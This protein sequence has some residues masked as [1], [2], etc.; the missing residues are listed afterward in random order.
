[1]FPLKRRIT[2]ILLEHTTDAADAEQDASVRIAA[3]SVAKQAINRINPESFNNQHRYAG[4]VIDALEKLSVEYR[5]TNGEF[6]DG[7]SDIQSIL[8]AIRSEYQA[9]MAC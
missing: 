5:D 9:S 3:V 1:M 6:T 4:A 8:G 7:R 2:I